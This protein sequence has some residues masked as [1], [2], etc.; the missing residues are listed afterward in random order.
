MLER[1][2]IVFIT[3]H[4][5]GR[6]LGCYGIAEVN[7]PALD[8]IAADGCR[9][10]RMFSTTA[11]CCASRAAMMTGLYGQHNGVMSQVNAPFLDSYR[12][13]VRH[14][15]H[16]LRDA[17]YHT[18]M[19]HIHHEARDID[20]LGFEAQYARWSALDEE[21][22]YP[23]NQ[24]ADSSA[25]LPA[26]QVAEEF[27]EFVHNK[28][29]IDRPFYAQ[30]GFKETHSGWDFDGVIPDVEKGVYVPDCLRE[31]KAWQ[32]DLPIFQ[33]AI[34]Y[35]DSAIG[36]IHDAIENTGLA[37]NTVFIYTSDHGIELGK[38]KMHL[39]DAGMG[40]PL[41]M[42][43]PRGGIAGG[44]LCDWLLSNIDIFPTLLE[45]VGIPVPKDI[46][47]V[48]FRGCFGDEPIPGIRDAVFAQFPDIHLGAREAR[49]I[50]TDQYK[51]IRNFFPATLSEFGLD[52][53]NLLPPF[54]QLFDLEKDP[55]EWN[56]VAEDSRYQN[57]RVEL[58]RRLMDWLI[59]TDDFILKG[60][61]PTLYHMA[62]LEDFRRAT[63]EQ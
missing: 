5:T 33:G 21:A 16:V 30:I 12:D 2:N 26:A 52:Y 14:I 4:D 47:G 11:M 31:N 44:R 23:T 19:F 56:D 61:R 38:A 36:T 10:T 6:H 59:K 60:P 1:P 43:W 35:M 53:Q 51:L 28:R 17:G 49:A 40:V 46:D 63:S 7:T 42:R 20:T 34:R 58:E 48:S 57:V 54:V 39:Y 62:A 50:R 24:M 8:S 45:L 13:G 55:G 27:V 32:E 25:Y 9:F 29:P 37:E 15:S 18:A 3:S 22:V 41:I